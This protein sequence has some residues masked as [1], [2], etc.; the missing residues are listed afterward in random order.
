MEAIYASR[1]EKES[2]NKSITDGKKKIP[3]KEI[4]FPTFVH[5][6]MQNK[7]KTKQ[8]VSQNC[9]NLAASLE[10]FDETDINMFKLFLKES[11]DKEELTFFLLIRK[12]IEKE[13]NV[14]FME[15]AKTEQY[16]KHQE[17]AGFL[18]A[19]LYLNVKNCHNSF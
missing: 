18:N 10:F 12:A 15:K 8:N 3:Y 14:S 2:L 19:K 6:Y 7:H 5:D 13:M 4:S 1:F 17:A 16:L 9:L 11:Y